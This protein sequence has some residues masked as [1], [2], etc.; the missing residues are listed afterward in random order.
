MNKR[1]F[2]DGSINDHA[3]SLCGEIL[4]QHETEKL[5]NELVAE[6]GTTAEKEMNNFFDKYEADHLQIIDSAIKTANLPQRIWKSIGAVVRVAAMV[7]AVLSIAGGIAVASSSSLRVYI[8]NLLSKST[9]EYTEI[10][11]SYTEYIDIP[12]AWHGTCY[13]F[14]I[15]A[16]TSID[17]VDEGDNYICVFFRNQAKTASSWNLFYGEYYDT[18]DIRIDTED[19]IEHDEIINGFDVKV[20]EK[21]DLIS[22][23]WSDSQRLYILQ[24][25][26]CSYFETL[27]YIQSIKP[28]K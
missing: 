9:P 20:Y 28:I 5:M 19:A 17:L 18:T 26:G 10:S 2:D 3:N 14:S 4:L 7:I 15:P 22:A 12:S 11:T 21:A 16:D 1:Y 8:L 24:T 23:Y 13:P 6:K 25:R 27:G